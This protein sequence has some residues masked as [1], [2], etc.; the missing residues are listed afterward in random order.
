MKK[1]IF[2]YR[3]YVLFALF[4]TSVVFIFGERVEDMPIF[5]WV[6]LFVADKAF[7]F[8]CGYAVYRLVKF[9]DSKGKIPFISKTINED[10]A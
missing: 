9:W 6:Y 2:N 10:E 7:G 8:L 4:F 3:Y 1:E 5:K